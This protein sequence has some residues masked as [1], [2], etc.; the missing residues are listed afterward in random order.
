MTALATLLAF[1]A[2]AAFALALTRYRSGVERVVVSCVSAYVALATVLSVVGGAASLTGSPLLHAASGP[3]I[4]AGS[5]GLATALLLRR[6]PGQQAPR[7]RWCRPAAWEL[8]ALVTGGGVLLLSVVVHAIH[9]PA[10]FD[11]LSYHLP[12]ARSLYDGGSVTAPTHF[13]HQQWLA[14]Q[15]VGNFPLAYPGAFEVVE[16]ALLHAF[17]DSTAWL[18]QALAAVVI[19]G[20]VGVAAV[21]LGGRPW[22][23]AAAALAAPLVVFQSGEAYDDLIGVAC[24]VAALLVLTRDDAGRSDVV[25]AAVLAGGAAATKTV[26]LP[27]SVAVLALC[28]L[29]RRDRPVTWPLLVLVFVVPAAVWWARDIALFHNPFFPVRLSLGPLHLPGLSQ[30]AYGL[31]AQQRNFVPRAA[32]WPVYPVFEK[33]SDTTGY[34]AAFVVVAVPA[35]VLASLTRVIR[36]SWWWRGWLVVTTVSLAAAIA[37]PLPTPRFQLLPVVLTFAFCGSLGQLWPGRERVVAAVAVVAVVVTAV[38]TVDRLRSTISAP[39]ARGEFYA[40]AAD[41]EPFAAGLPAGTRVWDDTSWSDYAFAAVY[42][43]MTSGHRRF[44]FVGALAGVAPTAACRRLPRGTDDVYTVSELNVQPADVTAVYA[45]PLFH[46]VATTQRTGPH[47]T[48]RRW[49]FAVSTQCRALAPG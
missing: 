45:E 3:L 46:L 43:L 4:A 14:H 28:L 2:A 27:V 33:Y 21:R 7:A 8:V 17:G 20:G 12:M 32:A 40:A 38:V 15:P 39:V 31:A 41:V 24:L 37:F 6:Q 35:A 29:R 13:L 26:M 30:S 18:L 42:P 34:G 22:F 47:R 1:A 9:P 19:A 11:A 36:R 23:P 44:V 5:L 49:L 10:G 16:G 25:L 48:Q